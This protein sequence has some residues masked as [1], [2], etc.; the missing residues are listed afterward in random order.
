MH[1]GSEH[2]V[3]VVAVG[4]R[5]VGGEPLLPR[6]VA[7]VAHAAHQV[8]ALLLRVAAAAQPAGRPPRRLA[9]HVQVRPAHARASWCAF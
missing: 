7:G 1:V 2:R 8:D 5:I 3:V 6:A 9:L 4:A